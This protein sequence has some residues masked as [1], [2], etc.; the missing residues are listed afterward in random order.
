MLGHGSSASQPQAPVAVPWLPLILQAELR[1]WDG[2]EKVLS[3]TFSHNGQNGLPGAFLLVSEE[4][5]GE[6]CKEET[7]VLLI[8]YSFLQKHLCTIVIDS[9]KDPMDAKTSLLVNKLFT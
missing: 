6:R 5:Y 2:G 9:G 4:E 7:S 8:Q 1:L 3:G